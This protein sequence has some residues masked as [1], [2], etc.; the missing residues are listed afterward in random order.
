MAN[1]RLPNGQVIQNAPDGITQSELVSLLKKNGHDVTWAMTEELS[2]EENTV[3]RA[4]KEATTSL[5]AGVADIIGM[6]P[7]LVLGLP[8]LIH[9]G[10]KE[11]PRRGSEEYG[12]LVNEM[13]VFSPDLAAGKSPVAIPNEVREQGGYKN[14]MKPFEMMKE[15][16]ENIGG[17]IGNIV[18]GS[19]E[20]IQKGADIAG[21]IF[22][23]GAGTSVVAGGRAGK[24]AIEKRIE[25]S[26][27]ERMD[28]NAT[29]NESRQ[30]AKEL[31]D[32]LTAASRALDEKVSGASK[33]L[34]QRL[35]S[36]QDRIYRG[37]TTSE[38]KK[39]IEELNARKASLML[40]IEL[41]RE[42]TAA[43]AKMK[44]E[45]AA[46]PAD[47]FGSDQPIPSL[48]GT[49]SSYNLTPEQRRAG[50]ADIQN[51]LELAARASE[52]R[53]SDLFQTPMEDLQRRT[54]EG[55]SSAREGEVKDFIPQDRTGNPPGVYP[56]LVERGQ[57]ESPIDRVIE[58]VKTIDF[59]V[60][61]DRAEQL[62]KDD[63][64]RLRDESKDVGSF[65]EHP[66]SS[67][68]AHLQI[69]NLQELRSLY[70]KDLGKEHVS[71]SHKLWIKNQLVKIREELNSLT[72]EGKVLD[73]KSKDL[74]SALINEH[75][76]ETPGYNGALMARQSQAHSIRSQL[77]GI[78]EFTKIPY[79]R[80][81]AKQ[82]LKD[83]TFN[84]RF[85]VR[86]GPIDINGITKTPEH[87]DFIGSYSPKNYR[88]TL[89]KE[90]LGQEAITLHEAVHARTHSAIEKAMLDHPDFR[91]L[92]PAVE[93]VSELYTSFKEVAIKSD[94]W[95]KI[96]K[97]Y[98]VSHVH[99][100]VAE[101]F[102]NPNFQS[103]LA[104]TQ[105][106]KNLRRGN[107][108][109]YWDL[110]VDRVGKLLGFD[111]SHHN[112][113]SELIK[114][115]ADIMEGLD[116]KGRRIYDTSTGK[117]GPFKDTS[118]GLEVGGYDINKFKQDLVDKGIKLP[119]TVAESMY[120]KQTKS[121]P[122]PETKDQ[123]V[124]TALRGVKGLKD[125]RRELMDDRPLNQL[126]EEI[127]A[128][129]D[130]TFA[131][132]NT[133]S[134]LGNP[135]Y[136]AKDHPTIAWSIS[137]INRVKNARTQEIHNFLFGETGNKKAPAP[138][139]FYHKWKDLTV[140]ERTEVNEVGQALN[141]SQTKLSL[142]AIQ[143]KSIEINK[144]PLSVAQIQAYHDRLAIN[145][146][147]LRKIN[148]RLL[149]EKKE[150]IAELPHY[151]SPAEFDGRFIVTITDPATGAKIVRGSYLRP[152]V[153]KLRAAFPGK[154]ISEPLERGRRASFDMEQYEVILRH[155]NKEMRDPATKALAEGWR[156]A[157]FGRHGL[158]RE[159]A[160]GSLGT[161]GGRKGLDRY[162]EVSE[163][164]IRQAHEYLGNRDIDKVYTEMVDFE[165]AKRQP[166]SHAFAL[167]ALDQARGGMNKT[168]QA[169][170]EGVGL[171][172]RSL[173]QIGSFGKVV[174]P[175]SV[176]RDVMK[177][178]NQIKSALL[179]GF[180][181][182]AFM[183][184]NLL[185]SGFALPKILGL[186][187]EYGGKNIVT[188]PV[189]VMKA[190]T[191][192]FTSL[193]DP[194]NK[195][196]KK[197]GDIGTFDASLK[198][199]WESYSSD[200]TKLRS[201]VKDHLTGMSTN[202]AIESHAVRKPAALMFLE[203]LREIGY[204][205]IAKTPDEIY[206]MTKNLT[207]DYMVA[208]QRHKKP[209]ALGRSGLVGTVMGPLQSFATTWLAQLREY[210]KL[211]AKSGQNPA[212]VLPLASFMAIS[213]LT[214]GMMNLIASKEY[215][216]VVSLLNSNF[217]MKLPMYEELM[218]TYVKSDFLRFGAIADI[219]GLNIGALF[220]P[221]TVTGSFA[222]GANFLIDVGDIFIKGL[223]SVGAFGEMN[224][225]KEA[226]KRDAIKAVFPRSTWWYWE[227]K[228]TPK[229]APTQTKKGSA[230][231]YTR[232]E[233]DKLA[234]MFSTYT[235]EEQKG[236][237]SQ[238]PAEQK[239]KQRSERLKTS[240]S[241][242]VD[243]LL[244]GDNPQARIGTLV[245]DLSE[246]QYSAKEIREALKEQ[247]KAKVTEKDIRMMGKGKTTRQKLLIQYWNSL[248]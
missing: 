189:A 242:M 68:F 95:E 211:A 108:T 114:A 8:G 101:G 60:R 85:E 212:N 151:W 26:R 233:K 7:G 186:A 223:R 35:L 115:G 99:E 246:D 70:E 96:L 67:D 146:A 41:T 165:P 45:K 215:D 216:A 199:D 72:T 193:L 94:K 16:A 63:L 148:E 9:T 214:A 168:M 77:E 149:S 116:S 205:K 66:I 176:I 224:K 106:P 239:M 100:F 118:G 65:K 31:D 200:L 201:T 126:A 44:A 197:L 2:N 155:L 196:I 34:D 187:S 243:A 54:S 164:Y 97:S 4:V 235:L 53:Q 167:E 19:P 5:G 160:G 210:S 178:A 145:S 195:D 190:T 104:R 50:T 11:G 194:K 137:Q 136:M 46:M 123:P 105:V 87:G 220:A 248:R 117:D 111:R 202:L 24:K 230:G 88:I 38:L 175:T 204:D 213:M 69:K 236:K 232:T 89:S 61:G 133:L 36:E 3:S 120:A 58:P 103:L 135:D 98:G 147:I 107:F 128:H 71:D 55:V 183:A 154:T 157:G 125:L 25:K 51:E 64:A 181:N 185:Q 119:D 127:S 225:L 91:H 83:P 110:F 93:R 76:P 32:Q 153:E 90:Y 227:D 39:V 134:K 6:T 112:Y 143:A 238:Y 17:G 47:L 74:G 237:M 247:F 59:E 84:P 162:E 150:P 169:L 86:T 192:A 40:R 152:N 231:P 180:F 23:L 208:M 21:F 109:L 140:K 102:T 42:Q 198:Y 240:T 57:F 12:Q 159:G 122:V 141:N 229:G 244:T 48:P 219:T 75:R 131:Q 113:L 207:E 228:Y 142:D 172:V 28:A 161:E 81:L 43:E 56:Q 171:A 10:I 173:V 163:K 73:F 170:S 222:P 121:K 33:N 62:F 79:Y 132:A 15:G 156:R 20:G 174:P 13:N 158:K 234:R 129:K 124:K 179:L 138:G 177:P 166:N 80:E 30:R 182:P 27:T 52:P 78:S 241:L 92:K 49:R 245:K 226:E 18:D 218:L 29:L 206:W 203:M 82:L 188:S 37:K 191:R 139:S 1:I 130:I 184:Q 22:D 14:L 209:H 221:P 144:R 217:N